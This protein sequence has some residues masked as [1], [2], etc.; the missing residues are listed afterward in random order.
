MLEHAQHSITR[1]APSTPVS[2]AAAGLWVGGAALQASDFPCGTP[3][4]HFF[5]WNE[6]VRRRDR[7]YVIACDIY[8]LVTA[9]GGDRAAHSAAASHLVCRPVI[10]ARRGDSLLL[11]RDAQ[12]PGGAAPAPAL[13]TANETIAALF[14]A[15]GSASISAHA[16][17]FATFER[18]E[19]QID[20]TALAER[21]PRLIASQRRVQPHRILVLRLS[22]LGDFVQ[23]LGPATAIRRHHAKDRVTLLTTAAFAEFAGRL[24]LF[25]DVMIDRRPRA[26]DLPGWLRLR[27][28]L[29]K[30]GYDRVYDLQTSQR[31]AAYYRLFQSGRTPEWSGIASGCSHPHANL[32]R[33]HQHTID[34]QAEQLL[35]AGI[36]PTPLPALPRLADEALSSPAER[37]YVLLVPGSSPQH[38]EKRWPAE[39][40]G[41]LA[42]ALY[43]AGFSSIVLGSG[44]EKGL[45]TIIREICPQAV[46][47]VGGTDLAEV[48]ALAR[49]AALAIGS[50]TGVIHLAAAAGCPIV[51][52]FSDDTDPL[53]CAPRGRIV[54]ILKAGCLRALDVDRVVRAVRETIASGTDVTA[55]QIPAGPTTA[56]A[57]ED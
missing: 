8:R 39:R 13:A 31:S 19:D 44:R 56:N 48:A 50:D 20:L 38:P 41:K 21:R 5:A 49:H 45:A 6:R 23:A 25:D 1:A 55:V 27:R 35:M 10:V 12:P 4:N 3:L 30:S 16:A 47:L 29:R 24:G 18:L 43:D 36:H 2:R 40:Y 7:R 22:A 42:R 46:D 26:L 37:P 34:K 52:L 54:R 9:L 17:L 14:A 57:A 53:L 28:L 33:D 51:V 15:I 32:E 11:A